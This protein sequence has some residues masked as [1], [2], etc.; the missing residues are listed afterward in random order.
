MLND[1]QEYGKLCYGDVAS[2]VWVSQSLGLFVHRV[3][4]RGVNHFRKTVPDGRLFIQ[5]QRDGWRED[6]PP[7]QLV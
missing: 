2:A 7:F 3:K 1:L 5:G 6:E 4:Q